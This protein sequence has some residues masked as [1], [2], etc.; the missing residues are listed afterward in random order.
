MDKNLNKVTLLL[1]STLT[2]FTG[3]I[4]EFSLAQILASI[5]GGTAYFYNLT[6]GL[7]TLTLGLGAFGYNFFEQKFRRRDLFI[8]LQL[9][10]SIIGI[11]SPLFL[12]EIKNLS[13]FLS[14]I[15]IIV[16]G[17]I[18]G[19]ELPLLMAERDSNSSQIIA[20]DY[21]GMFIGATLF[22]TLLLPQWGVFQTIFLASFINTASGILFWFYLKEAK[23]LSL[24]YLI[25]VATINVTAHFMGNSILKYASSKFI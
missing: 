7:F 5:Y 2:A 19:L 11:L 15:P 14:Y 23:K 21:V 25:L 1:L 24:I 10:L 13:L 4:Y 22:A 12:L 6:I 16:I 3:I 8:F 9:S 17:L 20:A 18:T